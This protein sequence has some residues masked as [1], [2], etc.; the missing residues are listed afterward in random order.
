[1]VGR[2]TRRAPGRCLGL[3]T[4]FYLWLLLAFALGTLWQPLVELGAA[5]F[6]VDNQEVM[7]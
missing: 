3:E 5:H 6:T 2:E 1:M 7:R 4:H